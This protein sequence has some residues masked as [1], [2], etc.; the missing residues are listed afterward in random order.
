MEDESF[1]RIPPNRDL[2]MTR[3]R[4]YTINVLKALYFGISYFLSHNILIALNNCQATASHF[5]N[6]NSSNTHSSL[7]RWLYAV[8]SFPI[9][10]METEALAN[11]TELI[12]YRA[13]IQ[14]RQSST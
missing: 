14:S 11:T 9:L 10:P 1:F 8:I 7:V 6:V 4:T 12:K 5:T 3:K 2:E 13:K